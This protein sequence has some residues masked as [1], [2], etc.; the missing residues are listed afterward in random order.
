MVGCQPKIPD[1]DQNLQILSLYFREIPAEEVTID[2]EKKVITVKAPEYLTEGAIIPYV[3]LTKQAELGSV[4]WRGLF[5]EGC[6]ECRKLDLFDKNDP[7]DAQRSVN[8]PRKTYTV[9]LLPRGP[10]TIDAAALAED[11]DSRDYSFK[12][13]DYG[14]NFF[15]LPFRNLHGNALPTQAKFTNLENKEVFVVKD[16]DITNGSNS[17]FFFQGTSSRINQLGIEIQSIEEK[18]TPGRYQVELTMKNGEVL[19][20]PES[21]TLKPGRL[22]VNN[23]QPN[24]EGS[25]V[26]PGGAFQLTGGQLY[27]D[28]LKVELVDTLGRAT[29]LTVAEASKYGER[30][31]IKLPASLEYEH[32]MMRIRDFTGQFEFCHQVHTRPGKLAANEIYYLGDYSSSCS[33]K[34]PLLFPKNQTIFLSA[35]SKAA[36]TR[37]KL[38]PA[39]DSTKTYFAESNLYFITQ[40][41]SSSIVR[42]SDDVPA[43]K[44]RVSLQVLDKAGK[45]TEE[46]PNFW[47]IVELK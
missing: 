6:P 31:V 26:R 18:L 8:V 25:R 47:R 46:G 35:N 15:F 40:L 21:V 19:T 17:S 38:I 3:E 10:L 13:T 23:W 37:L 20:T 4:N 30:A 39:Q 1:P 14:P 33:I 34:E 42:F 12:S 44:Y 5:Y 29:K 27:A 11:F 41:G 28:N 7:F 43:G 45:V 16:S 22:R 2:Q 36:K 9:T 24:Y 32:Y